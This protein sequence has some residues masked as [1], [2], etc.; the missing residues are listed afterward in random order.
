M[1]KVSNNNGLLNGHITGTGIT[2]LCKLNDFRPSPERLGR[3]GLE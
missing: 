1:E 2:P 3:K